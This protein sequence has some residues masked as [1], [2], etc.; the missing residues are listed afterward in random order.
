MYHPLPERNGLDNLYVWCVRFGELL[1]REL[2]HV[3]GDGDL[4]IALV[5]EFHILAEHVDDVAEDELFGSEHG[6]DILA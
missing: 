6:A 4:L 3:G 2:V 1:H 5:A